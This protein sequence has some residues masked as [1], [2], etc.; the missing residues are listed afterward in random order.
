MLNGISLAG[1]YDTGE[2]E[3]RKVTYEPPKLG[4][5]AHADVY[6]EALRTPDQIY[7]ATIEDGAPIRRNVNDLK[8][9]VRVYKELSN[10]HSRAKRQKRWQEKQAEDKELLQKFITAEETKARFS[11]SKKE[12]RALAVFKWRQKLHQ[13]R[14][15]EVRRR[16]I[17]RGDEARMERKEKRKENKARRRS[18]A[19]AQLVLEEAPN[20]VIPASV[21]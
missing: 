13:D 16:W 14:R 21:L 8:M 11:G 18:Q 5:A 1:H 3:A 4:Q 12:A 9:E 10:P 6:I 20:Q 15:T 7:S 19:L 17:K 2:A